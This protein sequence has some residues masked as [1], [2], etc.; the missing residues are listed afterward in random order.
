MYAR[1]LRKRGFGHDPMR[2]VE[3]KAGVASVRLLVMGIAIM[4]PEKIGEGKVRRFLAVYLVMV[5]QHRH[6]QY[7]SQ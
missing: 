3:W 4:Q 1:W 7:L 5:E 2:T 6:P